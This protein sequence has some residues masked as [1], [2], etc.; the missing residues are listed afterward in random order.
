MPSHCCRLLR[1][2]LEGML[3]LKDSEESSKAKGD[4]R[5]V[6]PVETTTSNALMSCDGA[7]YDW[8][9]QA[10]EGPT[11][12]SL[13]A[14][15]S[16]SSNSGI[17]L[18]LL[19]KVNAVRH[20]LLLLVTVNA[21]E[22]QF[23]SIVMVKTVNRE[24][25][26]QA[27]VDGKKIIITEST[28]RREI[29]LENAEGVDCL[30]NSTIFEQLTLMGNWIQ[31]YHAEMDWSLVRVAILLSS[32]EAE[33]DSQVVLQMRSQVAKKAG[34]HQLLKLERSSPEI[35]SLK[36]RVKRLEKK[37]G[38]RTHKLKRLYKIGRSARVISSDEA[39][40]GVIMMDASK[41][42]VLDDGRSVVSGRIMAEKEI[43]VAEKE[44]S[45]ADPVTTVGEV[46]TTA[47]VEIS[48]ASPTETIIADDLTLAQTLIEIK[49]KT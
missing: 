36:L 6:V 3:L 12:F 19:L 13:M 48:T 2:G 40:F 47:S 15:T 14:Y 41:L 38:S 4:T 1:R 42:G 39:S 24:V 28:V 20:N 22:E 23:W 7:G 32:L 46:V 29:Q 25:Q 10:E 11:N 37:G 49:C 9:D 31:G 35:T 18:L 26:L 33:Q 43:N 8:S 5:R 27:L 44:V 34:G 45:T 16:T 17:N 30:P 21:V